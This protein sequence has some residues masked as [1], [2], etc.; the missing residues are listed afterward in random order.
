MEAITALSIYADGAQA[1]LLKWATNE[2][3]DAFCDQLAGV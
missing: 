2:L 3:C 1:Q